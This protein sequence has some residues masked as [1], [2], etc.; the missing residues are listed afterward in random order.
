MAITVVNLNVP[1]GGA[2]GTS[3]DVHTLDTSKTFV[4]DGGIGP[5]ETL[6]VQGSGD[7]VGTSDVNRTWNGV[8]SFSGNAYPGKVVINHQATAYRVLRISPDANFNPTVQ[9]G[10]STLGTNTQFTLPLP[11]AQRGNATPGAALLVSAGGNQVTFYVGGNFAPAVDG[12]AQDVLV[13]EGSQDSNV[14]DG[15][16]SFTTNP[17]PCPLQNIQYTYWRVKRPINSGAVLTVF[18]QTALP[19]TGNPGSTG[20]TGPTGPA[21]TGS[22]GPTGLVGPTGPTGVG[23]AV[24]ATGPTGAGVAGPTGP[25][26]PGGGATGPTGPTGPGGT[27]PTGPAGTNGTNGA[28]G[29][30]GPTGP[31]GGT[32]GTGAVGPTGPTGVT[33]TTGAVGPTGLT[34]G[35]GAVG[36]TGP[37]GITGTTGAT[38]PTGPTSAFIDIFTSFGGGPS[39]GIG[40][41]TGAGASFW[42]QPTTNA[43]SQFVLGTD[44]TQWEWIATQN[45]TT[46]ILKVSVISFTGL[47]GGNLTV[48]M[49]IAGSQSVTI[50]IGGIASGGQFSVSGAQIVT[51]GQTF[52]I[53]VVGAGGAITTSFTANLHLT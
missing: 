47:A 8:L 23:G 48:V 32:G 36:P 27:G 24:G 50:G 11:T 19:G 30:T 21:G 13:I 4:I 28:V 53:K 38:G 35:T 16:I 46:A 7:P 22:T 44:P 42:M 40:T 1:T 17:G 41:F 6:V 31:S 15:I 34:G 12:V 25:T 39:P 2:P 14:W 18:A 10:A 5:A 20:P 45:C 9:V 51:A 26:G 43:A 33:G 3:S 49:T 52:G 29:P 37:T